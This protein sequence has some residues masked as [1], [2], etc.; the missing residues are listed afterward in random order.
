MRLA[1]GYQGARV[2]SRSQGVAGTERLDTLSKL[3]SNSAMA[4]I[5]ET[6]LYAPVKTFLEGQGYVVKA[7]VGAADVV[8]VRGEE[9]PVVVE[10]KAAFSLSLFHQGIARLGITDTVYV[11]VPR[12]QGK[13]WQTSLK[14]NISLARR[15][16]LGVVT[17]RLSDGLVQVH[18]DPGPY[19]P[20][21][22][23][24]RQARLLKEFARLV[25]D[26]NTGGATR[27]GLVTGYRSDALKCA[28]YLSEAGAEK[29]AV[30]ARAT[31][32]SQATTIMRDNHY[33]WFEKIETGIYRLSAQGR[34]GL[35]DWG[36]V[37]E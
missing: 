22:S 27:H 31:G 11:A 19:A 14:S 32:V 10:L 5:R 2:L 35:Q 4:I 13:R 16:G 37:L 3:R 20:R 18:C 23:A 30:V 29:G 12:G 25:G 34:K 36:D 28:A 7:E 33:G 1:R 6:E 17:V 21:K 9:P 24:K 26:P 15:L 8:A